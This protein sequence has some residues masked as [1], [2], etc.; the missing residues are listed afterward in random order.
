[1][2]LVLLATGLFVQ[3]QDKSAPPLI[4]GKDVAITQTE[5][6]KV[7]GY[8]HN[9]IFTYKGIPYAQAER[10]MAPSKPKPWQDVRSSLTYGPVCPLMDPTV[11]VMDESEFVFHHDW[12]FP[13]EDCLRLNVWSPGIKSAKDAKKRPVMV[14]LHGGGHTAGSSQELPSYDG[15]S[16]SRTGDVVIVSINHRLNVLGFLDLTAYG[17][18]YKNSPNASILDIIAALEWVKTNIENFGGDPAN[19]TIYGQSGGGGKVNTLLNAPAA[20][21]LF[22]KAIIQSGGLGLRFHEKAVTAKISK[23]LLEELH[24]QPAQVDS[25]QKISFPVLAAAA[26][27]SLA[28]VND[29]L[30]AEGKVTGL[31]GLSWGPGQDGNLLPFQPT[32]EKAKA[33]SSGIPLMIGS[34]KNEF[35]TSLFMPQLR[36]ASADQVQDHLRKQFGDKTDAYL[37]AVKKAYPND[38]R[39]TDLFDVDDMFRRSAVKMADLKFAGATAPIYMYL[40]AW[41]S[42]V[43]DGVYKSVHCME[44][45]FV[46]NNISRCEEMTGGG[47][48]AYALAEKVS[49]AWVNFA[50][51]GNPNHKGL[52]TWQK[53]SPEKGATMIFDNTCVEKYHHDKEFLAAT[54]DRT[55]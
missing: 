18:K 43:M 7:R 25:L 44:I 55:L 5:S 52:P 19:V 21:G 1:M 39:P 23:Y 33:L 31:F 11:S 16:L 51:T 10:F 14:W 40:F 27:K 48:E 20:K 13:N 4:T 24:L 12:G 45:P 26:K 47:K 36:Y 2:C 34:T 49:L 35:M 3:A 46:F 37:A 53:Y 9:G 30:K 15:E 32:D 54:P 41:Q 22:H 29:E 50:R 8:I 38:K 17:D 6:G 28:R 42:P